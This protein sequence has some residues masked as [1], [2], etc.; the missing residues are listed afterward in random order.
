M[1]RDS[2]FQLKENVMEKMTGFNGFEI[3]KMKVWDYETNINERFVV[4]I[5]ENG[6]CLAIPVPFED[7]FLNGKL[8]LNF[9]SWGHCKEIPPEPV[10]KMRKMTMG[11]IFNFNYDNR[12]VVR[13]P[14]YKNI[15]CPESI[16]LNNMSFKNCKYVIVPEDYKGDFTDLEFLPYEVEDE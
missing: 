14:E 8:A 13:C 6:E 7:D 12:V 9:T 10:K 16:S 5:D 1:A 3:R 2:L 15:V 11:E 4:C